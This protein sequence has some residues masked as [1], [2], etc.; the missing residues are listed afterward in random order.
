MT[1]IP[2]QEGL[3]EKAFLRLNELNNKKESIM[4]G[5]ALTPERILKFILAAAA[6]LFFAWTA[7]M[8]AS[9]LFSVI[10]KVVGDPMVIFR[11][12]GLT[13]YLFSF[14][15]LTF[16]YMYIRSNFGGRIDK[17]IW[18]DWLAFPLIFLSPLW[19]NYLFGSYFH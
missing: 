17:T 2:C 10:A 6:S 5:K 14:F 3:V 13:L 18:V 7:F 9:L 1:I 4:S 16:G 8:L 19:M 11:T 15:I 12:A